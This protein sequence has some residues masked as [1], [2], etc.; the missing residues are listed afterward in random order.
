MRVWLASFE[1]ALEPVLGSWVVRCA[2][3]IVFYVLARLRV[4]E[5]LKLPGVDSGAVFNAIAFGFLQAVALAVALCLVWAVPAAIWK[6][7]SIARS[8]RVRPK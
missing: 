4:D 5:A 2:F 7:V 1:L 6:R 8:N 3:L